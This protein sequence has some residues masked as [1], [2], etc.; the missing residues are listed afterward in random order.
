MLVVQALAAVASTPAQSVS[1]GFGTVGYRSIGHGR[2]LIL[3]TGYGGTTESW[4]RRFVDALAR[5]SSRE[6][7]SGS[8]RTPATPFLFQEQ[9]AFLPLLE[10]FL[11]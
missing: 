5:S 1:T 2:T 4:D 10:S 7:G 8:T 11:G 9:A 6:R 3:I